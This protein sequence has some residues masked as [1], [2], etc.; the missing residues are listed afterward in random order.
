[1]NNKTKK[2]QLKH[3][4]HLPKTCLAKLRKNNK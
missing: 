4:S 1:M 2:H 3:L